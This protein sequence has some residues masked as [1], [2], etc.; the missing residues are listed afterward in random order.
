MNRNKE[1]L[2][3]FIFILLRGMTTAQVTESTTSNSF[4]KFWNDWSVGFGINHNYLLGDLESLK[5]EEDDLDIGFG[6][7]VNKQFNPAFEMGLEYL[8]SKL[9][10]SDPGY[11]EDFQYRVATDFSLLGLNAKVYLNRLSDYIGRKSR[12]KSNL[13][14]TG[15]L[16][17]VDYEY[18]LEPRENNMK[19]TPAHGKPKGSGTAYGYSIGGGIEK[20]LSDRWFLDFRLMYSVLNDDFLD[21]DPTLFIPANDGDDAIVTARVGI[22]YNIGKNHG[23]SHKWNNGYGTYANDENSGLNSR[24]DEFESTLVSLKN[25]IYNLEQKEERVW[26]DSDG[27]KVHDDDDIEPNTPMGAMVNFLGKQIIVGESLV[28]YEKGTIL[29]D[30]VFFDLDKSI[31]NEEYYGELVTVV[32]YMRENKTSLLVLTG[33]ADESGDKE[34]N[35]KLSQKRVEHVRDL[36]VEKFNLSADRVELNWKGESDQIANENS[37]NRRVDFLLK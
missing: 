6:I 17:L 9:S 13:Y 3:L 10:G 18:A 14:L 5:H 12:P 30:P 27:D 24:L 2:L 31:L 29:F 7:Q 15:G 37:I 11:T 32:S 22:G 21:G 8:G 36:L 23:K 20:K 4:H 34:Y 19:E 35:D 1:L 16:N 26:K 33:H 25:N 28:T